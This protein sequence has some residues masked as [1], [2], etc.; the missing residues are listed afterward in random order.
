M[1]LLTRATSAASRSRSSS[2]FTSTCCTTPTTS[3][4]PAHSV[5]GRSKNCPPFKHVLPILGTK[6]VL[7]K[8]NNLAALINT[9]AKGCGTVGRSVLSKSSGLKFECSHRNIYLLRI[10]EK[11]KRKQNGTR[12][13]PIFIRAKDL[14]KKE[15]RS[16][17]C[18]VPKAY[19]HQCEQ[20]GRF[21]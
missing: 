7:N 9:L 13:Q 20:I 4:T 11:T 21:F 19:V 17:L 15:Q 18:A 16:K 10:V 6:I 14:I 3:R 12:N 1:K 5:A 2:R 8:C